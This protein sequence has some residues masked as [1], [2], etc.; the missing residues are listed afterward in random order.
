VVKIEGA[1]HYY[2]EDSDQRTL[3]TELESFLSA[4]L[5]DGLH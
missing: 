5:G 1:D 3:Y 4:N 2:L